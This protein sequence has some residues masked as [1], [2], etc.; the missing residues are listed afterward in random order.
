MIKKI[1]K[2]PK[3]VKMRENI[4]KI[5][6]SHK[7]SFNPEFTKKSKNKGVTNNSIEKLTE[8][9]NRQFT[10]NG[11]NLKLCQDTISPPI[12]LSKFQKHT[13]ILY[14]SLWENMS[15]HTLL[16][17]IQN[18][19]ISEKLTISNK[20]TCAL[21]L[22]PSNPTYRNLL[23]RQTSNNMKIYVFN[24]I[25]CSIFCNYKILKNI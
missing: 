7:K 18:E 16:V 13:N 10:K 12:R 4:C 9:I 14:M 22:Q 15:S 6:M 3:D 2:N 17:G 1:I 11:I 5:Y 19:K 24:F 23:W 20:T 25:H 21:I 8:D